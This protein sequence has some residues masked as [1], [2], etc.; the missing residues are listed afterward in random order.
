MNLL[1]YLQA[2][3]KSLIERC[4]VLFDLLYLFSMGRYSHW[5]VFQQKHLH[6]ACETWQ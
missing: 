5:I 2:F 1:G 4:Q 3:A 6:F